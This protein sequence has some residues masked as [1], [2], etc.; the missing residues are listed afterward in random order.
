MDTLATEGAQLH[1]HYTAPWR[2]SRVEA[3]PGALAPLAVG[4][5]A[6]EARGH[7]SVIGIGPGTKSW[8][9]PEATDLLIAATDIV[10]YGLYLDLIDDLIYKKTLHKSNYKKYRLIIN[11]L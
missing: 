11:L 6:S 10:G 9:T 1:R 2:C 7:L 8:R 5:S 4:H 3:A